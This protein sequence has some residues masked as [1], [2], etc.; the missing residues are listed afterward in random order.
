MKE[1]QTCDP[2]EATGRCQICICLRSAAF[3][4]LIW[5]RILRP[6]ALNFV[7]GHFSLP[8]GCCV[9]HVYIAHQQ[10]YLRHGP[11]NS[12]TRSG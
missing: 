12:P 7:R 3:T 2:R 5:D 1:A 4:V 8:A 10:S 11:S 6:L 9:Q